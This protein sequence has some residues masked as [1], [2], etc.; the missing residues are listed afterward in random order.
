MDII[1]GRR[2]IYLLLFVLIA[3]SGLVLFFNFL[4]KERYLVNLLL[5]ELAIGESFEI[6]VDGLGSFQRLYVN[7]VTL[8]GWKRGFSSNSYVLQMKFLD[9]GNIKNVFIEIKSGFNV[10]PLEGG[11]G[12]DYLP[13]DI[14]KILKKG[15]RLGL[16]IRYVPHNSEVSQKKLLDYLSKNQGKTSFEKEAYKLS[17]KSEFGDEQSSTEGLIDLFN[18]DNGFLRASQYLIT[19]ITIYD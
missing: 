4:T 5:S 7:G 11:R 2:L 17:V 13:K 18:L 3:L 12:E 10:T 6:N 1:T 9:D 19:N 14:P 8:V 16:S 15:D